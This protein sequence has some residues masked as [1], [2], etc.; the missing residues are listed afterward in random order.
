MS[1]PTRL[2]EGHHM[3]PDDVWK[4]YFGNIDPEDLLSRCDGSVNRAI[5][6]LFD[7]LPADLP[8]GDVAMIYAAVRD[9]YADETFAEVRR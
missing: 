1:Q 2:I 9:Y 7:Y 4:Y 6:W 8:Q 5:L 3:T